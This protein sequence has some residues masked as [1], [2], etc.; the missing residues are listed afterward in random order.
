M[1]INFSWGG[2]TG[3]TRD[4]H[5]LIQMA[6]TKGPEM[7]TRVVEALFRGYFER[8]QDITSHAFLEAAGVEAG[9][10]RSEV[11]GGLTSAPG[12]PAGDREVTVAPANLISGV[13]NFTIQGIFELRGAQEPDGFK[14]I[15]EKI[16]VMEG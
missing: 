9:L 5:R 10:E 11:Q 14:A 13:P 16:K 4:S 6:I 7:Q 2:R 12:G 1:G 15:F 3:N 8:E